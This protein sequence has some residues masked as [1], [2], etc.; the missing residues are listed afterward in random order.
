MT[1]SLQEKAY[2]NP[3]VLYL[4]ME[5]SAKKWRLAFIAST[6]LSAA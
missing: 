3:A 4:A 2:E 5:L 6:V 1:T